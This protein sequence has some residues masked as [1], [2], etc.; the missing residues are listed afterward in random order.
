[1]SLTHLWI[2]ISGL[3]LLF[4]VCLFLASVWESS[5]KKKVLSGQKAFN[6]RL[7]DG[8]PVYKPF[9]MVKKGDQ[10]HCFGVDID[11]KAMLP[12]PN[13]LALMRLSDP[14]IGDVEVPI[15]VHHCET[16]VV[17]GGKD[18]TIRK[19]EVYIFIQ[20]KIGKE[21]SILT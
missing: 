16:C 3:W 14:R 4:G 9:S 10:G 19:R 13:S 15:R 2:A 11:P 18:G 5:F 17:V 8:A 12:K 6:H 1:M 21:F 7:Y 20:D